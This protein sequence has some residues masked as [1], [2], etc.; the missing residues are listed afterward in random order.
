MTERELSR[1]AGLALASLNDPSSLAKNPLFGRCRLRPFEQLRALIENATTSLAP[2]ELPFSDKRRRHQE[3]ILRCDRRGETH[4]SVA[5]LLGISRREFYRERHDAL[6]R[7]ANEVLLSIDR[8]NSVGTLWGSVDRE[9]AAHAFIEASRWAGQYETVWRESR[10]LA[11]RYAGHVLEILLEV[12]AAEAALY[13][14]RLTDANAALE[15]ARVARKRYGHGEHAYSADLWVALGE[16]NLRWSAADIDGARAE[17]SRVDSDAPDQRASFDVNSTLYINVLGYMASLELDCGNWERARSLVTRAGALAKRGD[18]TVLRSLA[19]AGQ[20]L[21]RLW[22]HLSLRADGDVQR[23][24]AHYEEALRSDRSFGNL[25]SAG[26][27]AGYYASALGEAGLPRANEYAEYGLEIVRRYYRGDRLARLT[28]QLLPILLRRDVPD[29]RVAL[30]QVTPW[31]L[32]AR[33]TML[34]DLAQ[35]RISFQSAEYEWAAETADEVAERLTRCGMHA[36]ACEAQLI[37]LEARV[38][39]GHHQRVA[40]KVGELSDRAMVAPAQI[41]TRALDISHSLATA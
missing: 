16:I 3:I 22:G 14:G 38:R 4:K 11:P 8:P 5:A 2:G 33:D 36:W 34:I 40:R 12:L 10:A 41:R 35:A 27:T 13:L 31:D 39:L 17:F 1:A 24:I 18:N 30:A 37:A 15:R 25:G 26:M 20:S 21:P 23:S 9:H 6:V 19:I 32:G 29:A 7:L 28:L